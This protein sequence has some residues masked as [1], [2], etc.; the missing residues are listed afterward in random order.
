MAYGGLFMNGIGEIGLSEWAM[1]K[2][3]VEI[4][5]EWVPSN[6]HVAY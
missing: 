2:S 5:V 1:L 6:E 3:Q 4:C